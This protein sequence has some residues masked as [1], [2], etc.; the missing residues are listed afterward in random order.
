MSTRSKPYPYSLEILKMDTD[1][2]LN[3][4]P[5]CLYAFFCTLEPYEHA[6]ALALFLRIFMHSNS[7]LSNQMECMTQKCTFA[8]HIFQM[9][10]PLKNNKHPAIKFTKVIIGKIV[11]SANF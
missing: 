5:Y 9:L 1:G 4:I 7:D 10:S 11:K 3:A 2:L 8:F 6:F